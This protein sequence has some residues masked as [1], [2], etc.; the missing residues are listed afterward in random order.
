MSLTSRMFSTRMGTMDLY[1]ELPISEPNLPSKFL[2]INS[3]L[4][5]LLELRIALSDLYRAY[6]MFHDINMLSHLTIVIILL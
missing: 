5:P 3:S 4:N 2:L 6:Y 1:A